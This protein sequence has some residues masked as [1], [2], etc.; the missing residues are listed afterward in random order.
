MVKVS[1][2]TLRIRINDFPAAYLVS[3]GSKACLSITP[4]HHQF[5]GTSLY[6]FR[7]WNPVVP[8][9]PN[10]K[11]NMVYPY[12]SYIISTSFFSQMLLYWSLNNFENQMYIF[13]PY[14]IQYNYIHSQII[15]WN[16]FWLFLPQYTAIILFWIKYRSIKTPHFILFYNSIKYT[17]SYKAIYRF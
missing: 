12:S 5:A 3:H 15:W 14:L 11:T 6:R 4:H 10:P 17:L 8:W 2:N 7:I 13:F 9:E 1:C 16:S